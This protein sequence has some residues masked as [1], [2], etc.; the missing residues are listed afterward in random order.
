MGQTVTIFSLKM[1]SVM[2][3]SCLVFILQCGLS[4]ASDTINK[5]RYSLM[6]PCSDP[7]A[8]YDG[9]KFDVDV[10]IIPVYAYYRT[11]CPVTTIAECNGVCAG[12]GSPSKGTCDDLVINGEH[13]SVVKQGDVSNKI[14]A[15]I[16]LSVPDKKK[17]S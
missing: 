8:G 15:L 6:D 7:M 13:N 16:N 3:I 4:Q 12:I 2:K 10:K 5:E 17:D 11:K 1:D 9:T 14:H